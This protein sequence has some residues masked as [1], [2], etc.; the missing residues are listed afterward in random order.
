MPLLAT[1]VEGQQ[2]LEHKLSAL[3]AALDVQTLLDQSASLLLHNI[4]FRFLRAVDTQGQAFAPISV[5]R[6]KVKEKLYGDK[7]T[8]LYASGKL[9]RSLQV[10]QV[11]A[12]SRGI[13]TDVPYGKFHQFGTIK[14]P[15]REF[16]GFS[17][18][19]VQVVQDLLISRVVEALK[20][21]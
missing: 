10:F 19:D 21:Q 15:I 4:M 9:F 1:R 5:A 12:D 8:P 6:E 11:G 3:T 14:L 16:L 7:S 17:T 2:Q 20:V 18:S 13:G